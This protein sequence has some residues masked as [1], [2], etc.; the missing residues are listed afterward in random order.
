MTM[1]TKQI[2]GLS[3]GI[4]QYN[5]LGELPCA[6]NDARDLAAILHGGVLPAEVKLLLDADATKESILKELAWLAKIAG[7]T[8]TTIVQFSGHGGRQSSKL[9]ESAFFCPVEASMLEIEQ[10][11]ITSIEFTE[12]L[13]AI[14]SERLVVLLDTC[15]SGAIG[16]VR[17]CH[18]RIPVG[19]TGR[20][21]S[22]LIEGCGR[23]ILA[24]SRPDEPAWELKGMRNGLFTTYVLRA[25]RGEVARAD[26]TIWTSEVF[27]YVSRSV[28]QHGSQ[29]PY[30]K[31]IGE[32]FVVMVQ[33]RS[34]HDS[35]LQPRLLPSEIDQRALRI[36]MRRSYD[37]EELRLLCRD[38]GLTID[39]L[40]GRT[41]ETRLMDLIDHC[42]RHR[43]Y[44]QLLERIRIDRPHMFVGT[45]LIGSRL[46]S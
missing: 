39:D 37:G 28:R 1:N 41:F 12:A 42:Q 27:S 21:L 23:V 5:N 7:P 2:Y 25:L 33:N 36:A 40:P 15:Y 17:H 11:C 34:T 8:D 3:A 46:A 18:P 45:E 16:E 10:T 20:D 35:T 38:L 29:R 13:R 31:A 43:R 24:A 9:H 19:F 26:G 44:E 22:A 4:S 6:A 14:K 32:D 30:Q